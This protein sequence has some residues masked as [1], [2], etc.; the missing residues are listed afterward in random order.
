MDI[1]DNHKKKGKRRKKKKKQ[2][3]E[4]VE[5]FSE[6]ELMSEDCGEERSMGG[7]EVDEESEEELRRKLP[8]NQHPEAEVAVDHAGSS[9]STF[10]PWPKFLIVRGDGLRA[11]SLLKASRWLSELVD[12]VTGVNRQANGSLAVFVASR[13]ASDVVLGLSK[14]CDCPVEVSPHWSFDSRRGV[15]RSP[16]LLKETEEDL[17]SELASMGVVG[18]KRITRK[19]DGV[20]LPTPSVILT[21]RGHCLPESVKVGFLNVRV[22]PYVAN[23]LLCYR[24]FRYGHT[25][26]RCRGKAICARCG[27][28]DHLDDRLCE[29]PPC[30]RNCGEAH[31][32]FSHECAVWLRERDVQRVIAVEDVPFSEAVKRVPA[33]LPTGGLYSQV[34]AGESRLVRVSSPPQRVER[35][36]WQHRQSSSVL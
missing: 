27:A 3:E 34:V 22:R 26:A 6:N 5:L 23:P 35:G 2:E 36:T 24:C 11:L 14:V 31:S 21:F 18:V 29:K 10:G 12:G 33:P 19:A 13:E 7:E 20:D 4:E 28:N 25:K 15:M 32:A 1:P 16:D 17:L 30:C 8:V 9:A